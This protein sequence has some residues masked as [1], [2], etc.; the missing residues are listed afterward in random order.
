MDNQHKKINGYRDLPQAEIDLMNEIKA[1]GVKTRQLVEK[2]AAIERERPRKALDEG[3]YEAAHAAGQ[4][5]EEAVRWIG[6]AR[7]HLQQGFMALTRA[8]AKPGGF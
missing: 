1:H 2:V 5:E 4:A 7:T 6:I 3:G 8:V